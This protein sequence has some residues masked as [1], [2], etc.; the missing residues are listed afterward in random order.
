MTEL[1]IAPM[2]SQLLTNAPFCIRQ[3]A[4]GRIAQSR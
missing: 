1:F 4:K 2:T 3:N